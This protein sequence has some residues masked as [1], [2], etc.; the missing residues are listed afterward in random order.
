M[1]IF[2]FIK[3][4]VCLANTSAYTED[5]SF[6]DIEKFNYDN[7]S[8]T[9]NKD[10][11]I[12]EDKLNP[13]IPTIEIQPGTPKT[14]DSENDKKPKKLRI[15]AAMR[16][17]VWNYHT[18]KFGTECFCCCK[19]IKF[20]GSRKKPGFHCGHILAENVGGHIEFHNLRAVCKRCNVTMNTMHMYEFMIENNMKGLK[21]IKSGDPTYQIYLIINSFKERLNEK[22]REIITKMRDMNVKLD[23]CNKIFYD[24]GIL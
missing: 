7:N 18:N 20:K 16:K 6:K 22:D 17:K 10:E 23:M 9:N 21:H 15:S 3:K 12:E 2:S 19:K 13:Q 1:G 8:T 24:S 11:D 4:Y 14:D 5:D